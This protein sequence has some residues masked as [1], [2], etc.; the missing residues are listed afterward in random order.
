MPILRPLTGGGLALLVFAAACV[1]SEPSIVGPSSPGGA[2][3]GPPGNGPPGAPTC[4]AGKNACGERCVEPNDP[5]AC[6]PS[7]TP[8]V[9][10]AHGTVSCDGT[11]KVAC[12]PT[13]TACGGSCVDLMSDK[14][15]CGVC[16]RSCGEDACEQGRCP[17]KKV[18]DIDGALSLV[19]DPSYVVVK[20]DRSIEYG[21]KAGG[22]KTPLYNFSLWALGGT[23]LA[24]DATNVYFTGAPPSSGEGIYKRPIIGSSAPDKV[25]DITANRAG[26]LHEGTGFAWY[27]AYGIGGCTGTCAT[28]DFDL[29]SGPTGGQIVAGA[30]HPQHYV[31]IS[32]TGTGTV[33]RCQR[34]GCAPQDKLA[35]TPN[36]LSP[37]AIAV[38]GD[39]VYW[40]DLTNNS[41]E[42]GR[43][44]ACDVKGCSGAPKVLAKGL[45]PMPGIAVDAQGVYF[46]VDEGAATPAGKVMVCRN[47]VEGCGSTPETLAENL[48]HPGALTL[49]ATHVYWINAGTGEPLTGSVQR[50]VK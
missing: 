10:P 41:G 42:L 16:E 45:P 13:L 47:L 26:L 9:A 21:P 49:D 3:G 36:T 33:Y 25:G 43:V 35:E 34:P 37:R 28:P 7:C 18:F 20:T 24:I 30:A 22:T 29:G 5:T 46:T 1:G 19:V 39:N 32:D 31:W 27:D 15:H 12:E 48:I 6:G 11:C 38:F 4:P 23:G 2:D 44:L 8:C 17:T 40:T 14:S 50:V